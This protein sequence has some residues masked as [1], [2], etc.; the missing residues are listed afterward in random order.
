MYRVAIISAVPML[1]PIREKL[2]TSRVIA[3]TKQNSSES[4][5]HSRNTDLGMIEAQLRLARCGLAVVMLKSGKAA[6]T[7]ILAAENTKTVYERKQ[8]WQHRAE[9]VKNRTL[10][11]VWLKLAGTHGLPPNDQNHAVAAK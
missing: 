8:G 11:L 6:H 9:A 1:V 2:K 10:E 7:G 3:T 4:T 5:R